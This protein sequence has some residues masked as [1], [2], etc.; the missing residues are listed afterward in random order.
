MSKFSKLNTRQKF[1]A[2][3]LLLVFFAVFMIA[4]PLIGIA[5]GISIVAGLITKIIL[6]FYK[7]RLRIYVPPAQLK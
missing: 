5:I 1:I 4:L 6:K 3:V 2:I 7:P